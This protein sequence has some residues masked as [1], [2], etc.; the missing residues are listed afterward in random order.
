MKSYYLP[1]EYKGEGKILYI[2]STKALIYTGIG[3][4]IGWGINMLL[5]MIGLNFLLPLVI[6]FGFVGFA[7]G[8]F[9]MPESS[10]FEIT[11]KVGG[12][13]LDE[14]ILRWF[15]FKL[16]HNNIYIYKER[17]I[18]KVEEEDVKVEK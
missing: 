12:E 13:K 17:A 1:R 6:G 5:R 3:A 8:T 9:K 7:F 11:R 4:V 18:E 14:L 10:R 2:F 15:K 16:K